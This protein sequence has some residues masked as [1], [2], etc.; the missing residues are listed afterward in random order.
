ML[1]HEYAGLVKR[2]EPVVLAWFPI[3]PG[4]CFQDCAL[5]VGES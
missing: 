3:E 4:E 1:V 5:G 2:A